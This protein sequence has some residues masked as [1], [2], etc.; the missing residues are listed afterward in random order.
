MKNNRGNLLII[1]IIFLTAS[2]LIAQNVQC[3]EWKQM[4]PSEKI[5]VKTDNSNNNLDLAFFGGRYYLVFRTAPSHF[6]SNKT[7]MF[8]VSSTDMENWEYETDFYH[9][10]DLRE[11]RFIVYNE[12]LF[13]YYFEGGSS[14][15]RFQPKHVWVSETADGK[16]WSKPRTAGLDGFVPWRLK[17]RNDTMYLSAYYGVGLYSD[18]H[19]GNLRLFR[20]CDG[21]Q[22][23]PISDA[24]Q[25]EIAG[26]E[27][28]EFEFDKEGNLWGTVRL[29][30]EGSFTVYAHRDSLDKWHLTPSG[31]KYD[32]ALM[33]EQEGDIYVISRRNMDGKMDKAPHWLPD[34]LIQKYNQVRY[35]VT[36]KTTAL[37]KLNKK[38]GKLTHLL[39]FPGTGDNAYPALLKKTFNSFV[40]LNYTSGLQEKKSWIRG[41]LGKTFIYRLEFLIGK[42][43]ANKFSP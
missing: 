30:N 39:D 43:P 34:W 36:Q 23:E 14:R 20:S 33:F 41:Q 6:A 13:I 29:E 16:Q 26:A 12:H 8:V 3:S 5:N 4:L 21:Y 25:V 37:F 22:W 24:P 7:R 15:F 32:S 31:Y 27:E 40:M 1:G 17:T 19:A 28:G 10:N 35:S 18:H 9:G 2:R 11:P 38:E 42:G